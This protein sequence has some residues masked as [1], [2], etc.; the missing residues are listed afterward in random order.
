MAEVVPGF[1]DKLIGLLS[2]LR[3]G[4]EVLAV[5]VAVVL[6]LAAGATLI[7]DPGQRPCQLGWSST[8]PFAPWSSLVLV[9]LATA[10]LAAIPILRCLIRRFGPRAA[11]G[12][13]VGEPPG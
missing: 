13:G 5:I 2:R 3:K 10:C 7:P 11:K 8:C 6:F 9:A 4:L 1:F 12:L